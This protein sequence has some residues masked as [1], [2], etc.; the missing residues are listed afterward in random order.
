MAQDP[1]PEQRLG[2]LDGL[3]GRFDLLDD[4]GHTAFTGG[5]VALLPPGV[6]IQRGAVGVQQVLRAQF[7]PRPV[8]A[9]SGRL[10]VIQGTGQFPDLFAELVALQRR[11]GR[12][13]PVDSFEPL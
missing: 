13:V 6:T 1:R 10:T 3:P 8:Q 5:S 7:S 2:A 4:L 9:K 11:L 12:P